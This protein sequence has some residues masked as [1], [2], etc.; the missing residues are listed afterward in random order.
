[1]KL[2]IIVP[3]YN[4]GERI[5]PTLTTYGQF[6]DKKKEVEKDFDYELLVVL[7]GCKDNTLEV[8][9]K[10]QQKYSSIRILDLPKAGK[11]LAIVA[12]FQ[13][14]LKRKNDLIGFV[15][16]DMATRPEY[17]YDLVEKM[18]STDGIIASR[19][20]PKSVTIPKRPFVKQWGR[21]LVYHPLI[22][23]L[24]G[25]N[26]YDYQCG[27]KIFKREVIEIIV[28]HFTL[29][30]W[31]FDVE[32]LYL[33]KKYKFTI[34][35]APTTWYDQEGSKLVLFSSGVSMLSSLFKLRRNYW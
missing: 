17:F 27:A 14:A 2:S 21:K 33:C 8:V 1:M 24:F 20:M 6:F 11:G 23:M 4:E 22:W 7:N 3:A 16:A 15:D 30:Q 18:G 28:P 34:K 13:D 29:G 10:V 31:A 19:Y 5:A 26:Y 32:L 25:M 35:E 9:K 12:G